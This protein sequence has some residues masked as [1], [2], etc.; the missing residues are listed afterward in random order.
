MHILFYYPSTKLGGQ[1]TQ[2]LQITES[3]VE[4]GHKV[5]WLYQFDGV[6]KERIAEN[7]VIKKIKLPTYNKSRF[8]VLRI[9]NR[10]CYHFFGKMQIQ[11]YCKANEVDVILSSNTPDSITLSRVSM[12]LG[13]PHFRMLG[14]SMVQVE[15]HWLEKYESLNIDG[16]INGYFGWP[17]VF[18][19]LKEANISSS[20]F[21]EMPFAVDTNNFFPLTADERT[22]KRSKLGI[23]E[24]DLVIG[25]VGRVAKNMQV[26]NTV[27]LLEELSKR[28]YKGIK[29]LCVGGGD[30]YE[31]LKE[32]LQNKKLID[33]SILTGWIPF[34][35]M[36]DYINCM[37]GIPLLEEDPQ[38]GSI[39]REAMACGRVALSV[40]GVSGTQS[41]F[42]KPDCTILV[43]PENYI[44]DAA[45]KI[46]ELIEH[47]ERL[48]VL[49][50]NARS[51][52][53][54]E[55]QF[56]NQAQII[57]ECARNC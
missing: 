45:N 16:F 4:L 29:F 51:Y 35:E 53:E 19:E 36:N 54:K 22:K 43:K 50:E 10:W 56:K 39:V 2:L 5:S 8:G 40:D 32:I 25:W 28:N 38:G 11:N 30:D 31:H 9:L 12:S 21:I 3:L 42:M 18:D 57:I 13:I 44:F 55:L 20:K 23:N 15:P 34:D 14:G 49:G 17:A 41:L 33:R 7:A 24:D 48:K 37:D 1:Q 6:L 26:W 27:D 52:V 47:K 46:A